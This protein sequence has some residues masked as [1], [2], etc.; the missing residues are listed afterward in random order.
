MKRTL[1]T[2]IASL[3]LVAQAVAAETEST[4]LVTD[5]PL[6]L[7][8]GNRTIPDQGRGVAA[9]GGELLRDVPGVSGSRLGG[10]GIDPSIHGQDQTQLNILIDG[11]Y[12]HGGCPNRMDP[13]ASFANI[14]AYDRV[15]V[16]KGVQTLQY[17]GGGSGGTV[18]FERGAPQF[19]EGD[20]M[21]GKAAGSYAS[22]GDRYSLFGDLSV[23]SQQGYIRGVASYAEA[24][25]YEDGN[26]DEVR[27]GFED[28]GAT[29][30][31]GYTPDANT[32]LELSLEATRGDEVL[33]AGGM[34]A[35]QDDN[36]TVRLKFERDGGHGP[37]G[38]V[39]A[40]LYRTEVT[41]VMDNFSLR[42]LTSPMKME[43]ASSSDTTGGRVNT[44]IDALGAE[45]LIGV[46]YQRNEREAD[47]F[48][49]PT[50]GMLNSILWPGAEIEQKGLFAEGEWLLESR[51]AIKAGLRYDRVEAD[52]GRAGA[53]TA[54]MTPNQLYTMYYGT[55][56]EAQ[57][58]NNWG[59]L[60]RYE[61]DFSLGTWFLGL[62][63]AVR[64]ADATERYIAA[65]GTPGTRWVGNPG[66]DPEQHNQAELGAS[67]V[68]DRWTLG[69]L[70]YVDEVTDYILRDQATGR[71]GVLI[72]D[73][74]SIYRNVDARLIGFEI[75]TSLRIDDHWTVGA[76]LA[77]VR[78]RN[79]DD[80][81]NLSQIAPLEFRGSVDY[82]QGPWS[83]GLTLRAAADQNKVDLAS[84]QDVQQTPGWAVLDLRGSYRISKGASLDLGVDNLFDRSYAYHLNRGNAFEPEAIQINEPGRSIWAK[85]NIKW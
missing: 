76:D 8:G 26:G 68:R 23:G 6:P 13:P 47:R 33:Y 7:L 79:T 15:T 21:Q 64:T 84:G 9:D 65:N 12:V 53:T 51:A 5:E 85:I 29:V 44:R 56:A 10:K 58:E 24:E 54:M 16:L 48:A 40:E 81:R 1:I 2:G 45:W 59:G 18:L 38:R 19:A 80:D 74:S 35:P 57:T 42:P 70:V 32:R 61:R 83:A 50:L 20:N 11:A 63:R 37:F 34:D 67:I 14:E 72:A 69:G 17:G 25:N 31:L 77:Y 49:G 22:N 46:D 78:G 75:D 62:S 36:D 39:S 60:L 30:A 55:A 27:T 66:I 41:H 3:T 82:E 43:I 4:I 73:G 52:A 28:K 71:D